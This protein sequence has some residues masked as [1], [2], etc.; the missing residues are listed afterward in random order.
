MP[1]KTTDPD[2]IL[3][4]TEVLYRLD[5]EENEAIEREICQLIYTVFF[6][7]NLPSE[8]RYKI[9]NNMCRINRSASLDF[10]RL[11]YTIN[12]DDVAGVLAHMSSILNVCSRVLKKVVA[13]YEEQEEEMLT[14]NDTQ[15]QSRP[16]I[17]VLNKRKP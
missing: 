12:R 17:E 2:L 16:N 11:L 10:H 7:K 5:Y 14:D 8:D 9:L 1:P 3:D 13:M 4:L 15:N 6:H